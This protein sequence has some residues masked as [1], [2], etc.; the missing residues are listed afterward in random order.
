V[1]ETIFVCFSGYLLTLNDLADKIGKNI[2]FSYFQHWMPN[3]LH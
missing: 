3:V 2:G 1:T